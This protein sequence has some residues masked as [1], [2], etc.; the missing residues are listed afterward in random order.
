MIS[1]QRRCAGEGS[2]NG[3]THRDRRRARQCQPVGSIFF[4]FFLD[5]SSVP[6][7]LFG[8]E[9]LINSSLWSVRHSGSCFSAHLGYGRKIMLKCLNVSQ[10]LCVWFDVGEK[11]LW[12]VKNH[13]II[14]S[15]SETPNGE[16][17]DCHKH[18][19]GLYNCTCVLSVF[20]ST[21]QVLWETVS[22]FRM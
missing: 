1:T 8:F 18:E 21:S 3:R 4:F 14:L 13:I 17:A 15:D 2:Q 20:T 6:Q 5:P 19:G 16:K 11:K 22:W 10:T 12:K 9:T 7:S